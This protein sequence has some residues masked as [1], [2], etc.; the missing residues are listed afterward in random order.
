MP[1]VGIVSP[2]LIVRGLQSLSL[3]IKSFFPDSEMSPVG[4]YSKLNKHAPL[5]D[6]IQRPEAGVTSSI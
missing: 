3:T 4:W 2:D 6:D 5:A 1:R